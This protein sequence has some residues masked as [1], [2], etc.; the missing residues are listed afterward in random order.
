MNARAPAETELCLHS[1][2]QPRKLC[3]E[4]ESLD[5]LGWCAWWRHCFECLVSSSVLAYRRIN[6]NLMRASPLSKSN[7]S[8]GHCMHQNQI[9]LEH[10]KDED[11]FSK[12]NHKRSNIQTRK[13]KKNHG[14]L[15]NE[16][17]DNVP[18][19]IGLC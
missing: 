4:D 7:E 5:S 9:L 10:T 1:Q 15:P 16:S 19:L 11:T 6:S 2:S 12:Q 13:E 17:M 3:V 14:E 18:S 8:F